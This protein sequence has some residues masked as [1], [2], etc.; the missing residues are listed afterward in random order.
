[1]PAVGA[2][3]ALSAALAAACFVKAFG[4]TFLG[5]P[6]SKEAA[7]P[8]ETDPFSLT[9]MFA[10]AGLCLPCRDPA[11]LLH[12]CA[13]AGRHGD[14]RRELPLVHLPYLGRSLAARGISYNGLLVFGFGAGATA[15][16]VLFS[17]RDPQRQA[18]AGLGLQNYP[19]P[20]P[21]TQYTASTACSF[22]AC[23][24][25]LVFRPAREVTMPPR[26]APRGRPAVRLT[27]CCRTSLRADRCFVERVG[28]L[29]QPAPVLEHPPLYGRLRVRGLV[30]LLFV[31]A[32][33]P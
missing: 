21:E 23:S 30:G 13:G 24:E 33:W 2:L 14:G 7:N 18:G 4:V 15:A 3:L 16:D 19:D 8:R 10:L 31:L 11:G 9:S 29:G 22:A 5:R 25:L 32:L 17:I 28:V 12:R 27:E 20:R 6:R 1:M 26:A